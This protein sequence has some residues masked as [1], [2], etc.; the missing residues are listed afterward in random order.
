M[1]STVSPVFTRASEK[2]SKRNT[3]LHVWVGMVEEGF[4]NGRLTARWPCGRVTNRRTPVWLCSCDCGNLTLVRY[5]NLR[6]GNTISCGCMRKAASK[7]KVQALPHINITHGMSN[8]RE[9]SSYHSAQQRCNNPNND[10]WLDYG[11]RGIQFRFKTFEDFFKE[12][13]PR[14]LRTS[15]DRVDSNGHYE[16]GNVIWS[17]AK[18]QIQNRRCGHCPVLLRQIEQLQQD[19]AELR[20]E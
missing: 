3:S 20:G 12:L 9:Y 13:G 19:I 15:L 16:R 7:L 10:R 17:T 14:P 11:G 5:Y 4:K 1:D 6:S 18:E 2:I 8:S